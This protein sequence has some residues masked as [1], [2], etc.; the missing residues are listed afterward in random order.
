MTNDQQHNLLLML[1][2]LAETEDGKLALS[3]LIPDLEALF[4][5]VDLADPDGREGF[6]D[7]WGEL[8]MSYALALH[9]S[10]EPMDETSERLMW[11]A[12]EN[13][14]TLVAAKLR[15]G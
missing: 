12:V 1:S 5:A 9:R 15:Q 6:W 3:S 2:K 8:E 4:N 13:L 11:E 7:S 10:S 14:K